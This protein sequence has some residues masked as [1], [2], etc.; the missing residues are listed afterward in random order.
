MANEWAIPTP[1]NEQLELLTQLRL[2]ATGRARVRRA[3]LQDAAHIMRRVESVFET[4]YSY[5]WSH[6]SVATLSR[7][8]E[9]MVELVQRTVDLRIEE[10]LDHA[11]EEDIW[12]QVC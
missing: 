9:R 12:R 2:R 7:L 10:I 1:N 11:S 4:R 8:E 5:Y 3:V 6:V